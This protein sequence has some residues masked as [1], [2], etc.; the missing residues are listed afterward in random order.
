M[1]RR[2]SSQP[3]RTLLPVRLS[4]KVL[5]E[6][7]PPELS[8][9]QWLDYSRRDIDAFKSLVR[10]LKRL[11]KSPPLPDPLPDPPPVPIS[12]LS[13]LRAKIETD[14]QL[15][16]QDQIQLLFELR[17]Q[18]RRGDPAKEIVDLLQRLKSR[19]DLFARVSRDVDDLL[20]VI[21][22]GRSREEAAHSIVKP[23]GSIDNHRRRFDF[24][25]RTTLAGLCMKRRIIQDRT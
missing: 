25:R 6:S 2:L 19:D 20:R 5:P 10:T 11:P 4:S 9:L 8:E 15:Q 17:Q 23:T 22:G 12:Y 3:S 14:S 1:P 18:I 21:H 7:L 24:W 16:F 13:S